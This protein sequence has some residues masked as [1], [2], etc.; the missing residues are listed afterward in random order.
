MKLI[1]LMVVRNEDWVIGA[2]LDAALRWCDGAAILLDRCTDNTEDEVAR[3]A[4]YAGKRV[5]VGAIKSGDGWDEMSHRQ[6]N[7]ESG[8]MIGGTHFAIVDGD[9]I[10]THNLLPSIRDAVSGLQPGHVLDI[11]MIPVWD[12]LDTYRV[13][14]PTWSKAYITA[15]F[16]DHPSLT[17]Q[18]AHDGYQHHNRPPINHL[19][20]VRKWQHEDGGVMHLQFA[21]QRRLLAKHVWYRMSDYLRWPDRD[22]AAKINWRYDLALKP[23]G[24]LSPVPPTW[25]GNY[26]KDDIRLDGCPY[27]EGL[28]ADAIATHGRDRF[29]GLDLKGF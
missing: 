24:M 12:S 21:N 6:T 25:W 1:A 9:E 4:H 27:Q 11:P 20:R 28:I 17:W 16:A 22:T 15:A 18:P 14:C 19:D 26:R 23:G 13:E 2:T 10:L 29:H 3:V 5:T 8:R 7:L